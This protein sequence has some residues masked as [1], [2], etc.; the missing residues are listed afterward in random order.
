MEE[1]QGTWLGAALDDNRLFFTGWMQQSYTA[2]TDSVSNQPM[3]WNDRANEYLLQQAWFR[4]ARRE[5][6]TGTTEPQWGFDID[7]LVGSDYR[8]T[9]PRGLFNS[10]LV[11]STGA[12]NLYGVDPI[13]HYLSLY[14]PNIF[15]GVELLFGRIYTPICVESLEAVSNP[16]ISRCYMFNFDPFTHCGLAANITFS[17]EWSALL[18][19]ANGNDI[20]F[21]GDG[22]ELRFVG[23]LKWTQPGGRN[24]VQ[25]NTS[26]GRGK[27]NASF[28]FNPATVGALAAEPLGR[29]NANVFDLIWTHT[30]SPRLTYSAEALFAYQTNVPGIA[31]STNYGTATWMSVM[32][33][34]TYTIAPPLTAVVRLENFDDFQG[35]R[36]GFE[37]LYTAVT[38]GLQ[39]RLSRSIQVRPEL[40]YDYNNE[41]R[42]FEGRHDLFTA[43]ADMIIRW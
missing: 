13:R 33:Y 32:H 6:T 14:L 24:V 28:P 43:A 40:R 12:N 25:F 30:L 16:L 17:P 21:G 37:G 31:N 18:M 42:P 39:V 41:S 4:F 3:V 38:G 5:I 15:Q 9:L 27:F 35:Q 8:F 1:V 10:Q 7:V 19:L 34:L 2:S 11:N 29:N 26:V 22:E 36:T 20:Y 23:S